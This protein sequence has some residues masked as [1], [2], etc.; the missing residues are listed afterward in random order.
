MISLGLFKAPSVP[1]LAWGQNE[2]KK[3]KKMAETEPKK[4]KCIIVGRCAPLSAP[5]RILRGV[6]A[7][8]KMHLYNPARE[9]KCFLMV[10]KS[11][12][13]ERQNGLEMALDV[14]KK[15][16][17]LIGAAAQFGCPV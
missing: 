16:A 2:A 12:A 9:Q 5:I 11:M 7:L 10:Q 14:V 6:A 3:V 8:Q 1:K 4:P 17:V 13:C 15:A